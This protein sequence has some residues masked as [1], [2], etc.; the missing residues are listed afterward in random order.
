MNTFHVGAKVTVLIPV[1]YEG[2]I[3]REGTRPWW[4]NRSGE[5]ELRD[6]RHGWM[7]ENPTTGAVEEYPETLLKLTE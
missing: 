3:V 6:P 7:V 4:N 5:A 1:K 2:V